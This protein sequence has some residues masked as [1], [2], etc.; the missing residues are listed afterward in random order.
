MGQFRR[1]GCFYL[2]FKQIL[3][4][5]VNKTEFDNFL[6]KISSKI[7]LMFAFIEPISAVDPEDR[8]F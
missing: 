4:H 6:C 2:S 7:K 5:F 8:N 3:Q 1:M